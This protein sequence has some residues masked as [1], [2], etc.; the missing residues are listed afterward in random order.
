VY[1]RPIIRQGLGEGDLVLQTWL[2]RNPDNTQALLFQA[3]LQALLRHH[4]KAIGTY[5]RLLEIDPGHDVARLRLAKVLLEYLIYPQA[6]PHLEHLLRR[7]PE[8]LLVVVMLAQCRRGQ[9]RDAEAEQLLDNLLACRPDFGVALAERG[10]LAL[11]RGQP[12]RAAAWLGAALEQQPGNYEVR[13]Q[14]MQCLEQLGKAGEADRQRHFMKQVEADLKR[15][16]AITSGEMQ[17]RPH[18]AALCQELGQLL[19]RIGQTEDGVQWLQ[20][21]LQED[22]RCA[23]AHEALAAYYQWA[24]DA[25]RLAHHRPFLSGPRTTP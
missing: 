9:G 10:R 18:D 1:T 24:G 13:Y 5:Q 7:Q 25:E 4:A 15:L 19:L 23:A 16:D 11:E 3:G 14:L 12:D 6:A 8:N 20:Q 2:K 22:P 17:K 21:A